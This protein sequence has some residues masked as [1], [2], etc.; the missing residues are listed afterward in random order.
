MMWWLVRGWW[1]WSLSSGCRAAHFSFWAALVVD[2]GW[3]GVF[4]GEYFLI[5]ANP[6]PKGNPFA[7]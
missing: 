1:W 4:L 3:L 6:C 2:P 7:D 5:P